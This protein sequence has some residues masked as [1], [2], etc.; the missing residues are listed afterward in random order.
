[1]STQT[2]HQIS[3]GA[4]NLKPLAV[5]KLNSGDPSPNGFNR[6][7]LRV[8]GMRTTGQLNHDFI[9]GLNPNG[10]GFTS[11]SPASQNRWVV[12]PLLIR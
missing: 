9:K 12:Q 3:L 5:A 4:I 2:E 7:A 11:Q 8:T 6:L 10:L 1:M